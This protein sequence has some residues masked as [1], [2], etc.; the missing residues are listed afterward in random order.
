METPLTEASPES[1]D[2]LF[3]RDPLDLNDQ[4]IDKIVAQFQAKR[5]L[6]NNEETLAKKEGRRPS[7]KKKG[8]VTKSKEEAKAIGLDSL[9]I[10]L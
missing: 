8:G 10:K 4:E 5:V 2:E 1:I 6:W 9:D 3:S 7:Y